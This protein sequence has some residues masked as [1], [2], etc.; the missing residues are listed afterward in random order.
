[1]IA[2]LQTSARRDWLIGTG[3]GAYAVVIALAPG[4]TVKAALA[5]PLLLAPILLWLLRS[6]TAWLGCFFF[7]AA[8]L[9]PLPIRLGDSGPH[10]AIVFAAIGMWIGLLRL[11]EWRFHLN[12]PATALLLLSALLMAT[13]AMAAVNSG[14]VI[15]AKSFARVVLFG[16]SVYVFLYA[17]SGPAR[18]PAAQG[19]RWIRLLFW[20]ATLSALF[21]CVDF[22]FQ[23]PAPAGYEQQFLWL[24]TGIFRRAQGVFYESSTLGN[25]CAFF[26]EMI[27]VAL[28][29][30][31]GAHLPSLL[32]MTLGGSAL[33]AALMLSYS[34]GSLVNLGVAIAVLLWMHRD[35]LRRPRVLGI[36]A[37]FGA[38]AALLLAFVFPVFTS[39][40]WARVAAA[41][42]YFS[43][44]P[45]LVLSGRLASWQLLGQYLIAH[46]WHALIGVGYKTLPYSDFIGT[47]AV[48]DNTYL[49]AL[50]ETGIAG[51][52]AVITLNIAILRAAYRAARAGDALR[53]FCGTWML[54]FWAGQSVQMLSA[55][56]LTYWR[57]LPAYFF[58]LALA[59]AVP[60]DEHPLSRSVQ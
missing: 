55:D 57:V 20:L 24:D 56:L 5:A 47:T 7:C 44:S 8:L 17:R 53:S 29:R 11:G 37:V 28:F 35:R 9:P 43:E 31:R 3:I 18:C 10:I 33:L 4:P 42:Q 32:G 2:D 30:P 51:F 34:R 49:T 15:A 50:V 23:F 45:N 58:V 40:Y 6:P 21:A 1:M 36:T 59:T 39:V 13:I 48:G 12:A 54:C 25:W 27:A 22:Y 38:S 19:F 41:F 26:L 14:A 16:V 46:P 60:R 52:T